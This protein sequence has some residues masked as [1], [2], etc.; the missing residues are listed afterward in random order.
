MS[1]P[2]PLDG[3]V[4]GG[5]DQ[6]TRA[7]CNYRLLTNFLYKPSSKSFAV[8]VIILENGRSVAKFMDTQVDGHTYEAQ[9]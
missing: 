7:G 4:I 6:R 5:R 1:I 9:F 3:N 8:K 2:F